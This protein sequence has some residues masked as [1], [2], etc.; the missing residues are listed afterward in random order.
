MVHNP[1]RDLVIRTTIACGVLET[2]AVVLR[3]VARWRSNVTIAV[4][5]WLLMA[6]LIPSY[7]MLVNGLLSALTC[8]PMVR[9]SLFMA[10]VGDSGHHWRCW[11]TS[12]D[13][14]TFRITKFPQGPNH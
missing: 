1:G 4:D 5:D 8:F 3:M 10:D 13:A 6:S 12:G 7:A 11:P 2:V 9:A 14:D